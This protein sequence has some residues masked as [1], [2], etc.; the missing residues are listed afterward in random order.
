[1]P[2]ESRGTDRK[3]PP[4]YATLLVLFTLLFWS[5][6]V[7]FAH[8]FKPK[9]ERGHAGIVTN[10]LKDISRITAKGNTLKFSARAILQIRDATAGVDEFFS[11]RGELATSTAHCDNEL[12]P[13]C[14]GRIR[15][16]RQSIIDNLK[17][18]ATRNGAEARRQLGRA[19]H[20]LQDFYSHSNWI[21]LGNGAPSSGL[22]AGTLG[23][24]GLFDQTCDLLSASF[25]TEFGLTS[26]TTGYFPFFFPGKCLHGLVPFQGI[27]KDTPTRTGF[28]DAEG[29]ATAATK[30]FVESIL[31]ATDVAGNDLAIAE[32]MDA[33]GTIGLI[34]DDTGSMGPEISGVK[35]AAAEIVNFVESN[36][37]VVPTDF[38]LERYGDPDVGEPFITKSASALLTAVNAISPFGG[39]DCPELAQEALF[40]AVNGGEVRSQ[41]FFFSDASS[42]DSSKSGKVL[43]AANKKKTVINYILTGSCSPVDPAYVTVA[44]GTGGQVFLIFPSETNRIFSL[45]EPAL[46]GDLEPLLIVKDVH[47]GTPKEYVVPVDSTV[48]GVTFSVSSDVLSSVQIFRPTGVAVSPS[49]P[50]VTVTSLSTGQITTVSSPEVGDW[51]LVVSGAGDLFV[52]ILGNS[53]IALNNF[54]FVEDRG[55]DEHTGL[56]P[57]FGQPVVSSEPSLAVSNVIGP[58]GTAN[59][60]LRSETGDVIQTIDLLSGDVAGVPGTAFDDFVGDFVL[61]PERFRVY[62]R[63]T[64]EGGASYQRAFP[65]VFLARSVSITADISL[66]EVSPGGT[67][68][69]TLQVVNLGAP[70]PFAISASQTFGP[71]TSVSPSIVTLGEGESAEVMVVLTVPNDVE[72]GARGLLTAEVQGSGAEE[73]NNATTINLL[74]TEGGAMQVAI[75]VKPGNAA[76]VLNLGSEG[77]IPVAILSS[78]VSAGGDFDFDATTV[79]PATLTLQG[80]LARERGNSGNFGSEIDVNGDGLLDFL[81][82]FGTSELDLTEFDDKLRLDGQTLESVSIMGMDSV[83]VVPAE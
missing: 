35:S 58:I 7:R 11:S 38:L 61:P 13:E 22:V 49:D 39:G 28:N 80:A 32:F 64:D 1:M 8:G 70:D 46:R 19:L 33:L 72:T 42:K 69:V 24:L 55:R 82:N 36:P 12:L 21:E 71:A 67:F 44:Q 48:T 50:D 79:D 14:S 30:S 59:F 76:N 15:D 40:R 68:T 10:G 5:S 65:Q 45:I 3:N 66:L 2:K 56:F 74:V 16:I 41:L 75:D 9:D 31:N 77:V 52:S 27:H 20:T 37:D 17:D 34:I 4:R 83:T 18:D 73:A 62:V 47:D 63:G 54:D 51:R 60:E 53:P 43:S 26:I 6:D 57:I 78:S 25:L 29:V 81:V 23:A